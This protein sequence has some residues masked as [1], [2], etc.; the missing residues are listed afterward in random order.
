MG[1]LE[2]PAS[3]SLSSK[4]CGYGFAFL[5][6]FDGLSSSVSTAPGLLPL[7]TDLSPY[8]AAYGSV[9]RVTSGVLSS[10]FSLSSDSGSITGEDGGDDHVP[11]ADDAGEDGGSNKSVVRI[12]NMEREKRSDSG[13]RHKQHHVR[14]RCASSN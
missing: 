14:T 2:H 3:L 9:T 11:A 1:D 13:I 10:S 8:E 6:L 5:D 4:M 12:G 7:F